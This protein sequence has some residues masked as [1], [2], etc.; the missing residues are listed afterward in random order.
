MLLALLCLAMPQ[1]LLAQHGEN[2]DEADFHQNHFSIFLGG[3][4]ESEED[5]TSWRQPTTERGGAKC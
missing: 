1:G 2:A 5:E 4:T 3:T